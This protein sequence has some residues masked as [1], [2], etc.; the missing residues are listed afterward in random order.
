M[1][2]LIRRKPERCK[3]VRYDVRRTSEVC[4]TRSGKCK[5]SRHT[6]DDLLCIPS[7]HTKI[8]HR[9]CR[10][11]CAE[12]RRLTKTTRLCGEPPDFIAVGA[13][14]RLHLRHGG[15][16]LRGGLDHAI[17]RCGKHARRSNS[18]SESR[19]CAGKILPGRR[20]CHLCIL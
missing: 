5:K 1:R 16:K 18:I 8:A 17:E 14:N 19:L 2:G 20:L 7:S 6:R 12:L 13:G 9:L 11:L 4:T 3:V 15:F 10:L